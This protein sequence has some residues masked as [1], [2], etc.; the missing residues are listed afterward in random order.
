MLL[1]PRTRL[2]TMPFL[3]GFIILMVLAAG[4]GDSLGQAAAAEVKKP[5]P[6][7]LKKILADFD[8]YAEEAR[9]AWQVP[10][11]AL[12]V[13]L[14][15]KVV[16]AKGYGVK[17]VG[18]SEKVDEHTIF[19]IGSTTK[20][21]TSLLMAMQVDTKKLNW[22]DRVVEHLPEFQM[23]DPWVTRE[24]M[25]ED[26]MA[27]HTGLPAYAGD[28]QALM[29]FDRAHL[30]HSLYYFKPAT[31]FR[32]TYAYQNIPFLVAA[33]L[34][35]KYTGKS[36]EANI[37]DRLLLPLEMTS[38]STSLE[39]FNAAKNRTYLHIKKDGQVVAL[40]RDWAYNYWVYTYGPAGG[41]NSN[42]IDMAKWLR[43]QLG[44]GTFQGRQL[45]SAKNLEYLHSPKTIVGPMAGEMSYYCEGWVLTER[46]PYPLIWHT[47][48][49]TGNNTIVALVPQAGV[50]LVLLANL[51]SGLPFDLT[52]TFYDRFF[53]NPPKDW[54][55][56]IQDK[57]AREKAA[58]PAPYPP[59]APAPPLPLERYAGVYQNSAYGQIRIAAE[60]KALTAR[61]GPKEVKANLSPWDR[62]TFKFTWPDA[63]DTDELNL[64]VFTIGP[65]GW[66]QN[67][68]LNWDEGAEFKKVEAKPA[69]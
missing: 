69:S 42:V 2:W 54:R 25:V 63:S 20:A 35:E 53:G 38:S 67:L 10:G 40:P 43:L 41:I 52:W 31:S 47:G 30:I 51:T 22:S 24:F 58:K 17:K 36:W 56:I 5:T 49:T 29:G 15:D 21:F 14:D 39:A 26:L 11:M 46:R 4:L 64:A 12:A 3:L 57:E 7:E 16:F 48:G 8:Q 45:V 55:Q 34:V 32:S 28:N 68:S 62:D 1:Q 27:Q 37:K 6:E 33:A 13:V 66:A 19:Q 18:G 65:D 60:N 59:A 50:G 44:Q 9:Q 61:C 23:F